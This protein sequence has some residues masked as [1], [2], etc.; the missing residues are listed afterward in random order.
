MASDRVIA[1]DGIAHDNRM[2]EEK[3]SDLVKVF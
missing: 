3:A 2:L 1:V